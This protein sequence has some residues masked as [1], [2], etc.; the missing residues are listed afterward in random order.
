MG[1]G[2]M[3][4]E[5]AIIALP[6]RKRC[7]VHK[8]RAK[9]SMISPR[10]EPMKWSCGAQHFRV[11]KPSTYIGIIQSTTPAIDPN[12]EEDDRRSLPPAVDWTKSVE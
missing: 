6:S 4:G 9:N 8:K 1:M 7:V 11:G 12:N 10:T 3:F 2:G 5:A